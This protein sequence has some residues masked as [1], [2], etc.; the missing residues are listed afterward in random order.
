MKKI[1]LAVMVLAVMAA[2][3]GKTEKAAT[4]TVAEEGASIE[5]AQAEVKAHSSKL[6]AK[7]VMR[8][9]TYNKTP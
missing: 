8:S 2:G 7:H 9:M 4:V 1:V 3:C 6:K 5:A